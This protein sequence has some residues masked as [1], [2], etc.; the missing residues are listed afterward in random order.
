MQIWYVVSK[1]MAKRKFDNTLLEEC[2]TRD[3]ATL[4]N[5]QEKLNR[6]AFVEFK[7][8]CTTVFKKR[9][10]SICEIGGAF[11]Q[12]CT[13][14]N[15]HTKIKSNNL[16][17]Y[18]VASTAQL[19][20]VKSKTK[21]TM[22]NKYGVEF[23]GQIQSGKDQ[24]KLTNLNKYG[25]EHPNQN[26]EIKA[27]TRNR[28]LEKYGV[29]STAQL[30]SV[31][32]KAKLTNLQR[33]GTEWTHQNEEVKD[34]AKKTNIRKYGVENPFQAESCK[35]KSKK[36]CLEKYGKEH[37]QMNPDIRAKVI[38]SCIDKY[39]VECPLQSKH[40]IAKGV[41]TNIRRYGVEHASQNQEIMERT[42][43]NSKKYKKF[44]MPSGEVRMVQGYEPFAIKN[45]LDIYSAEQIKSDR[46]DVPRV[47]YIVNGKKH[48]HFPDIY[49]PHENK[50]IEVKS[51]WTYK[52]KI[53]N[54]LE[55]KKACEEQGYIY[56]IWCYDAKG[57]RVAI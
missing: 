46:K 26:P 51:T 36:T 52:C 11:C 16:I 29:V 14:K 45:L 31:K 28:N 7:C 54:I 37:C 6:D 9:F 44:V 43:K 17:K 33:Y 10:R 57:K 32:N 56:E 41:Q 13:D 23:A 35:L 30:E 20:S 39:G 22:I 25:T 34:K 38:K 48:Y 5:C 21:Q 12:Q 24:A 49:I 18:G 15:R 27:R 1:K 53:S 40:V 50:L 8:L 4:V 42:Q 3:G 55:K 47:Q 2:L 19:E